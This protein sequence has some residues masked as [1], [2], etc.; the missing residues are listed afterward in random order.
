MADTLSEDALETFMVEAERLR[1]DDPHAAL[2]RVTHAP[3]RIAGR[4]ELR[5]L[6]ADLIWEVEGAAKARPELEKLVAD[7]QDYADARHM[8]G[9]ICEELGDEPAKIHEYREVLRLDEAFDAMDGIDLEGIE[10]LIVS[11][12]EHAL[13]E[14]PERF[15]QKILGVPILVELR[16]SADLVEEGLDPRSLGLFDGPTDL[17]HE[18]AQAS[19]TPTRIVLYS[20]NLLAESID[21][22][23]LQEEVETT[24][25]HEVGHYFGLEEEDLMRMGLD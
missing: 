8:L 6:K 23:Q 7:E 12:A 18:N 5:L 9:I 13:E 11:A 1:D 19:T 20:A 24:V 2:E 10:S 16:P 25:L 3:P 21:E 4:P 14:L 17:D 22:E 15:R